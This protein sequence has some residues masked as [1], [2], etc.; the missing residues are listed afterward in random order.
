[1]I[2]ELYQ[3]IK[4]PKISKTRL[5][6]LIPA[7]NDVDQMKMTHP[8]HPYGVL[9]HSIIAAQSVESMFLRLALIFHDTGKLYTETL[10]PNRDIPGQFIT[11]HHGHEAESVKFAQKILQNELDSQTLSRLLK[12]IE[13]HDTQL[14]TGDNTA[15]MDMLLRQYGQSFVADLLTM[16]QADLSAHSKDYAKKYQPRLDNAVAAFKSKCAATAQHPTSTDIDIIQ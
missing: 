1:M 3:I 9:D 16:Q 4:E 2:N 13:Y 15:V 5:L 8:A 11:K 6:A 14:I 12:I 10:V 7:L